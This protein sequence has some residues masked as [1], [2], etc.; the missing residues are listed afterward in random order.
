[1]STRTHL[2][3]RVSPHLQRTGPACA[4]SSVSPHW[5]AQRGK[6]PA[7]TEPDR[8]FEKSRCDAVARRL[9]RVR[10][11][12][13]LSSFCRSVPRLGASAGTGT[14]AL[15]ARGG[16]A[17]DRQVCT[18]DRVEARGAHA[19]RAAFAERG[20]AADVRQCRALFAIAGGG[21]WVAAVHRRRALGGPGSVVATAFSAAASSQ[22]PRAGPRRV[23]RGRARPRASACVRAG[24]LEPR[25]PGDARRAGT[26]SAARPTAAAHGTVFR[27]RELAGVSAAGEDALPDAPDQARAAQL[28][29]AQGAS[30]AGDDSFAFT[31][32]KIREVL[33]E[34]L[35][36]IRRRRL[37][38]RIGETLEKL[39]A[40]PDGNAPSSDEPAQDLAYHFALAADLAKSFM[41][42]QRATRSAEHVFAHDDALKFLEQARESA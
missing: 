16:G 9:L 6:N 25:A 26:P 20:A 22:R 11:D 32:D 42:A 18:R 12:D 10:G 14:I 37:H 28:M 39:H 33:Y 21:A 19:Q 7:R 27:F 36:P 8:A 17:R 23:P 1:L 38:Q 40:I 30:S 29:R 35:N 31:H 41:Y 2:C 34:E 5:R 24:R 4:R 3:S 15:G 13:A